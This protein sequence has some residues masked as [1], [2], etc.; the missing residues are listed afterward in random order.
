MSAHHQ[1]DLVTVRRVRAV[2]NGTAGEKFQ[3]ESRTVPDDAALADH[4]A[5]CVPGH[6]HQVPVA[7][8]EIVDHVARVGFRDRGERL[9]V[10][11][12]HRSDFLG[13]RIALPGV[14]EPAVLSQDQS[15]RPRLLQ[16]LRRPHHPAARVV[17]AED[18][19]QHPV[20]VADVLE[21]AEDAGGDVEDVAFLQHHLARRAP[22]PPEEAPA[23]REHEEDFRGA[24]QVQGVSAFRRL[25]GGADVEPGR[26]PDVD[27]LLG[28]LRDAG[29]DDGEVLLPVGAGGMGV[30]ERAAAGNELAVANDAPVHF[31]RSQCTCSWGR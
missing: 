5:R 31:G 10:E 24:V 25:A 30:D 21:A 6:R 16:H 22:A 27:V 11:R 13:Q 1:Q 8:D 7:G 2:G 29:A 4:G 15:V 17:A 9:I 20:V 26:L 3:L 28:V 12:W 19:H 14:V 18:R 23:A